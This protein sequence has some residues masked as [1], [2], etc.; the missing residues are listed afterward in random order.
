[1]FIG[2]KIVQENSTG[3]G[4]ITDIRMISS[5]GGYTSLPTATISGD[6]FISLETV[7]SNVSSTDFSR[8]ELEQVVDF[9][10]ISFSVLNVRTQLSYY[11]VKI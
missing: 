7:T 4:D 6:R 1:M 8:I 9:Y 5:G 3:V 11:M 2:N 10:L